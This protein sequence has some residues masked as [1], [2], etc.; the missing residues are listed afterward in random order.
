[1]RR[2]VPH[3]SVGLIRGVAT[4]AASRGITTV[5]AAMSPALSRL[6]DRFG[7]AFENLGPVVEYHGPR[8]PCMADCES[9]L[10]GMARRN[11]GY[12]QVVEPIYRRATQGGV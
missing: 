11:S 3:I 6:L 5:C 2:L 1:M 7:L 9:L 4:L 12:Y 10:D 8:Q